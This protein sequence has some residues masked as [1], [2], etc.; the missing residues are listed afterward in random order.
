[1]TARRMLVVA[2]GRTS[3]VVVGSDA[4]FGIEA[5]SAAVASVVAETISSATPVATVAFA[6]PPGSATADRTT[7]VAATLPPWLGA[8]GTDQPWLASAAV[9]YELGVVF[10]VAAAAS[11]VVVVAPG[12]ASGS[13]V[14]GLAGPKR[15]GMI[16]PLPRRRQHCC[17][18]HRP[19]SSDVPYHAAAASVEA[20]TVTCLDSSHRFL[21]ADVGGSASPPNP[22]FVASAASFPGPYFPFLRRSQSDAVAE[23]HCHCQEEWA[24][25]CAH[26]SSPSCPLHHPDWIACHAFFWACA[27]TESDDL[28]SFPPSGVKYW[29]R[30][31]AT[32]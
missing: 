13:S 25:W 19:E 7:A 18:Y 6:L 23:I 9:H 17:N 28:F 15:R 26:P 32:S 3:I 21:P 24:A 2:S 12:V 5:A 11:E 29:P 8:D 30:V 14:V 16:P 22:G 10:A 31:V 20:R 4:P 1:M 27:T